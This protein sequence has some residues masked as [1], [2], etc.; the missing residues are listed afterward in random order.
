MT[1]YQESKLD[2]LQRVLEILSNNL[3]IYAHVKR[4]VDLVETLNRVLTSIRET[5]QQQAKVSI[6]GYSAEKQ[7][8]L[9]EVIA[10]SVKI[11][12]AMYVIA[13]DKNDKVLLSSMSINKSMF[14]HGH[15]ND[16]LTLA[17]NIITEAKKYTSELREYGIEDNDFIQLD[18]AIS[19]YKNF[20]NRPQIAKEERALHTKNLKELFS[21]ADSILYDQLDKLIVLFK[22]TSPDFYFSYKTARNIINYAKRNRKEE[23]E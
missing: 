11:A 10:G 4:M 14:Y 8:T 9:E 15:A 19:N 12:N 13:F 17:T 22:T 23:E 18:E 2:M 6:G 1:D 5:A 16:A 3:K 20:I 7:K 21:E